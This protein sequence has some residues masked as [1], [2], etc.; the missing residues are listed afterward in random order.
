M[1]ILRA[2]TEV[3][4]ELGYRRTQMADVAARI[5][6]AKGTLYL[7][8]ASK[9]ALFDQVLMNA[10]RPDAPATPAVLPV[11]TPRPAETVQRLRERIG[12]EG[13][14][15]ALEAALTRRRRGDVRDEVQAIVR[16]LY[17]LLVRH[18][19]AIKLID[20]CAH[21]YP[22]LAELW[23]SAGRGGALAQLQRYITTRVRQKRLPA[24]VDAAISARLVLET[25]AWWAIHRHWD[26]E[27]QTFSDAHAEAAIVQFVTRALLGR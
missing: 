24:V 26:P 18:R 6:V 17:R 9:E 4:L 2:A 21:D 14:M 10:D 16:E 11:P 23:F 25:A 5:G 20:R 3:F 12:R 1:A 13:G 27:P 19:I 7:Y 8:V 22:A 15:A